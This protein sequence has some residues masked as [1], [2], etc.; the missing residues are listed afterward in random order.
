MTMIEKLKNNKKAIVLLIL[1]LFMVCIGI[2]YAYW[3]LTKSQSGSNQ[4]VT[5][6]FD[7]E[8][9]EETDAITLSKAYPMTDQEGSSLTPYTFKISNKCAAY[10]SY[11]IN[12][13]ILN[14]TTLDSQYVKGMLDTNAKVLT[15]NEVVK[16]TLE[17]A[18]TSYKL[19]T[20]YL[21]KNEERTH[22]FR[23][24]IDENVGMDD[25]VS[26]KTFEGK[27]TITASYIT[28]IPT[29]YDL[30]VEK[31]GEDSI[32]GS[33][34]AGLDDTGKCPTVNEDGTVK[35]S[36]AERTNGYLCSAPDDYG[37]SYYY[38][39]NVKNN[40]VKF[41]NT[42]WRITRINGDGSVRMI[43]AGD[44]SVID[45]LDNKEE[46][47]KNGYN[48]G[49]TD[50]TQI[51]E[52]SYNYY[53]KK[54]NVQESVNSHLF[55]DNAGVG[56]MY[57]NRDGIVEGSTEYSTSS[58]T[59]TTTRYYAKEYTY[60]AAKDRFTLKDPVGLLG[61]EITGDYVGW[62]TMD[63]TSSSSSNSYVYKITSVTP[64]DGSSAAKVGYSYVTYGTTSKEKA[65]TNTN[66]STIKEKV[67]EWYESHI[68][69]TEYE[70]YISDTLFC[71]DRS[72]GS[73]TDSSYSQLAYGTERT[74][75]RG[76]S[77]SNGITLNCVQQN[78]RF[79]VDD[80]TIGNGDLTYPIGLLTTDEAFLA[81]GISS[82]SKYY[83]YTGN[84]YWTMSPNYFNGYGAGARYV[85][86]T[87]AADYYTTVINSYGVRPVINLKPN[88]LNTG[89]GT[90]SNPYRALPNA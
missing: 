6:C 30:C 20:E 3:F 78:D 82:N 19:A 63:S 70:S 71:N 50:Y 42:Y 25:P 72:L 35:V 41:A 32:N 86:S 68:K 26:N 62:Y 27:I 16:T 58:H 64:S 87:G 39:G 61:T 59:A 60:N 89:D 51:G 13:E 57:G 23:L 85:A 76:Y 21:D 9:V 38:R 43:Y 33:I 46:V 17:N 84:T 28:E 54:D 12:L 56:Y 48:D 4:V 66:D 40:W 15:E 88:S 67:D 90:A 36:S 53:W 10:V 49:S 22:T 8:F 37:T 79:T 73:N 1:I 74:K 44:A 55:Y 77:S 65:Q 81:G 2:S 45:A 34:I 80:E 14:T 75:Y 29:D 24:W 47:L 5:D 31:Y 11:Q 52:S 83:L 69:G 7:I 18:T